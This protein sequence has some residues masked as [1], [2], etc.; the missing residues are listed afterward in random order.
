M[1]MSRARGHGVSVPN[2]LCKSGYL[3]QNGLTVCGCIR[4]AVCTSEEAARALC[5]CVALHLHRVVAVAVAVAVAVVLCRETICYGF[6]LVSLYGMAC[7]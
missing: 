6:A 7:V 5:P 1:Q 2:R 4:L 3:R